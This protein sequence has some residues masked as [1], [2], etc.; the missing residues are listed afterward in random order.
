MIPYGWTVLLRCGQT[1][2]S[3]FPKGLYSPHKIANHLE[4]NSLKLL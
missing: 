4:I 1:L 3:D 2:N